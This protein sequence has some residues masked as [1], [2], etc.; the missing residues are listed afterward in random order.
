MVKWRWGRYNRPEVADVLSGP[1]L[2]SPPPP[3]HYANLKTI[4]RNAREQ[5]KL[6]KISEGNNKKTES[7]SG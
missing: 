7:G 3:P 1:S 4:E 2:D 6:K 5:K